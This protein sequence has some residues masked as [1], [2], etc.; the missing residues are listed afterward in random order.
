MMFA[1]EKAKPE[2][3]SN[4]KITAVSLSSNPLIT[5]ELANMPG[6]SKDTETFYI[7]KALYLDI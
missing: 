1:T 6:Q 3:T 2:Q 4:S 5:V 7:F